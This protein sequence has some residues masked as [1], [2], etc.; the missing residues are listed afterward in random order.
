MSTSRRYA[1]GSMP[2]SW[3]EAMSESIRSASRIMAPIEAAA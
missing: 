2:W 3:Q 1:Q